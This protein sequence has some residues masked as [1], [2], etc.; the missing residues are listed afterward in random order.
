M[1]LTNVV[2]RNNFLLPRI[3]CP[4]VADIANFDWHENQTLLKK[5]DTIIDSGVI[6]VEQEILSV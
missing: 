1:L 3:I 5:H 2:Y 6:H 4:I